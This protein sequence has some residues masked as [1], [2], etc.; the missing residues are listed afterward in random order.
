MA[1]G[2]LPKDLSM[3]NIILGLRRAID[4]MVIF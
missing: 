4:G 1:F 2:D 3:Y